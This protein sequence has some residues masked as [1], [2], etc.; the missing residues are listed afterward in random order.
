MEQRH[1]QDQGL[2]DQGDQGDAQ[3]DIQGGGVAG[4]LGDGYQIVFFR[5]A[6][7]CVIGLV[8]AL[9][10]AAAGGLELVG[11][12]SEILYGLADIA[13]AGGRGDGQIS[14]VHDERVRRHT[15]GHVGQHAV[16]AQGL[17]QVIPKGGIDADLDKAV[18]Q[19]LFVAKAY[20]DKL[21]VFAGDLIRHGLQY[22]V[23]RAF[24]QGL[25]GMGGSG[26]VFAELEM[27]VGGV[28]DGHLPIPVIDVDVLNPEIFAQLRQVI[29]GDVFLAL[30]FDIV[31]GDATLDQVLLVEPVVE[32]LLVA[33]EGF[34]GG[35]AGIG[36]DLHGVQVVGD[37]VEHLDIPAHAEYA[38]REHQAVGRQL[39]AQVHAVQL[40]LAHRQGDK[41]DEQPQYGAGDHADEYRPGHVENVFPHADA[42]DDVEGPEGHDGAEEHGV[43]RR[44]QPEPAVFTGKEDQAPQVDIFGVCF[45]GEV[46][47]VEVGNALVVHDAG[48]QGAFLDIDEVAVFERDDHQRISDLVLVGMGQDFAG[49]LRG[50]GDETVAADGQAR[51]AVHGGAAVQYI[52]GGPAVG[53][54]FLG[55]GEAH[56]PR[57]RAPH[58]QRFIGRDQRLLVGVQRWHQLGHL[59]IGGPDLRIDGLEKTSVKGGQG[60]DETGDERQRPHQVHPHFAPEQLLFI[61]RPLIGFLLSHSFQLPH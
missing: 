7:P 31:P 30:G 26:G 36:V 10:E 17:V 15:H 14:L 61:G 58:Y 52:P 3:G 4:A 55:Q 53:D 49:L 24:K 57:L 33:L 23:I 39:L 5:F 8:A 18:G 37:V 51:N 28:G 50:D 9:Q 54:G 29:A 1:Q 48:G 20:A 2:P 45:V 25:E 41:V 46:V 47:Q 21:D 42:A 34:Q 43:R 40:M 19:V 44:G 22:D 11:V 60:H 38:D 56:F 13:E 32:Q 59:D 12:V 35:D 16:H 6:E 27:I